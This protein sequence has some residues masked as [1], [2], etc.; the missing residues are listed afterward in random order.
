MFGRLRMRLNT[1]PY[2]RRLLLSYI[3][4]TCL[5]TLTFSIL[6]V[7]LTNIIAQSESR[8]LRQLVTVVNADL[9]S[10]LADIN[11]T[12][13]DIVIDTAIRESL[14]KT[15]D[16]DVARARTKV[17]SIL[18]IKLI[19]SN[20]LRSIM[21]MDTSLHMFSPNVTLLLP[22]DYNL[23]DTQAYRDAEKEHGSLVWLSENDIYDRYA[24]GG[25]YRP[26]TNIHAAA[27]IMDYSHQKFL[28]LMILSLNQTYFNSITYPSELLSGSRLF[29]V[30]PDKKRVYGVAGND[31]GLSGE[32]LSRLSL[33]GGD[34]QLMDQDRLLVYRY[35][36]TMGWFLVSVTKMTV[37]NQG[38]TEITVS[39]LIVLAA[40]LALAFL[41]SRRLAAQGS[42]GIAELIEGM[43]KVEHEDFDVE[44]PVIRQDELGRITQAFNHMV[45]R[46][47]E[48]ILTEYREKLLMQEAQFKAL[49]SQIRPHFLMNTFDMLHWK[50]V[51]HGQN[52]LAETV[53]A[54]SHLMQYSMASGSWHVTLEQELQN[55]REYLSVHII[56]R[57][58]DIR[59]ETAV[60]GA[61]EV[62]LPRQTLQPIVENAVL[63]GFA[64]REH[65]NIL[66][67]NGRFENESGVYALGIADNGA[68]MPREEVEE[69]NRLL[70]EP[71]KAAQ[72]HIGLQN[73]AARLSYMNAASSISVESEYG[74]GTQVL[75]RIQDARRVGSE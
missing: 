72:R 55:V 59:L 56:I 53:V 61:S 15:E 11:S 21:I 23:T 14:N 40:C 4:L 58:C 73:V 30:S 1:I 10:R 2:K 28:G 19:S 27:V 41:F 68:G 74:S 18:K 52:E 63:H 65:G 16:I 6:T 50:L 75:I 37:L 38:V 60:E 39:L 34:G 36:N 33:T 25:M 42:R 64:G 32:D 20:Y 35:N 51:E 26:D 45:R 66:R 49:Q 70:R 29:L 57:G 54:L 69:I 67:I 8:H 47:R 5:L 71:G 22:D 9:E 44:V 24:A 3:G 46:I 12:G 62:Y 13:F 48:L 31:S 7:L 43:E 17:E